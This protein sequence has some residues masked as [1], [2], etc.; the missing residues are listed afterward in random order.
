MISTQIEILIGNGKTLDDAKFRK[1]GFMKFDDNSRSGHKARE[2]KE[3]KLNATGSFLKL[4]CHKNHENE[5]NF[6]QQV[7]IVGLEVS[8]IAGLASTSVLLFPN[9]NAPTRSLSDSTR[10]RTR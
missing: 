9:P 10:G 2:L 6:C 8:E 4:R 7:G 3:V 5:H 1:L